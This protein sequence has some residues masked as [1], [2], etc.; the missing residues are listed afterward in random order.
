[1]GNDQIVKLWNLQDG[2]LIR[3]MP[4]HESHIYN[5][6]FHPNGKQLATGDL[7]CKVIDW[8]IETGKQLR[9]FQAESLQKYDNTFKA[10]IGGFRGMTFNADGKQLIVCGITNVSNAFAGVG[11][12]S[13]VVFDWDKG[14]KQVEHLTKGKIQAVA[15]GV[16]AH[17]AGIHIAATGGGNGGHL[18]FWK[19][20]DAEEFHLFKLPNTARDLSLSPDGLHVATAHFDGH[21][22]VSKLDKKA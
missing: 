12:P 21:V 5:V 22:R 7:T 20:A 6:A 10:V 3:E 13:V 17:P 1:V 15:W 11:N 9:T 4:G 18:A 19:P 16:A 14:E 2:K 8:E